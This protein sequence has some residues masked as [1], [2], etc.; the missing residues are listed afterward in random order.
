MVRNAIGFELTRGDQ[1]AVI[2]VPFDNDKWSMFEQEKTLKEQ[3]EFWRRIITYV[4]LVL[5][6]IVVLVMLRSISKSLGEA[7]NP[8]IPE[9]EI[10]N[11]EDVEEAVMDIP[12]HVA[13]SNELLEK[14]EIMT[15]NDPQNV[16]KIIKDWL[17]EPVLTKKD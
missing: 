14:V 4:A 11:L 9:V 12:L 13:R 16:A 6:V 7:M 3:E 8:P 10:P 1:V 15:E 2:N 5:I 17:N